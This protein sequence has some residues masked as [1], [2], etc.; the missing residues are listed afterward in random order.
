MNERAEIPQTK[1]RWW[2]EANVLIGI[3]GVVATIIVGVVTYWLTAGS[4]SREYNE[5]FKAARND[6]LTAVAR[7]IGEGVVPSK[8]KVQSV[9]NSMRR[10]YGIKD[11]DFESPET[12]IDDILARVLAN[13]FLDAKRREEL[14]NKLLAVKA[15]KAAGSEE[16]KATE[17]KPGRLEVDRFAALPIAVAAAMLAAM[18][19]RLM[20]ERFKR[21]IRE[22][23]LGREESAP[24]RDRLEL[25]LRQAV[26]TLTA[27]VGIVVVM[28]FLFTVAGK[29]P[30]IWLF[31][32]R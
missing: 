24:S 5:R 3:G 15:E 16:K 11:Q 12:V 31:F 20:A 17:L 2:K 21:T 9:P 29:A 1:K 19:L 26:L 18:T 30:G 27:L 28:W 14:S 6:V 32:R 22:V 7:S 8:E 23:G 25:L 4:V 13:E 10:Q